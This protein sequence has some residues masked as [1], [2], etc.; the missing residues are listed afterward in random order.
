MQPLRPDPSN[1]YHSQRAPVSS[2]ADNRTSE[3]VQNTLAASSSSE[4]RAPMKGKQNYQ[5]LQPSTGSHPIPPIPSSFAEPRA[6]MRGKQATQQ[7]LQPPEN[8]I[9]VFHPA[10]QRT[11]YFTEPS[12]LLEPRAPMRGQQALQQPLQP[13]SNAVPGVHYSIPAIPGNLAGSSVP[14]ESR[15]PMRGQ[16]APQ[17]PLQPSSGAAAVV[18]SQTMAPLGQMPSDAHAPMK[19]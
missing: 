6:P 13:S 2:S 19:R 18:Y 10:P 14:S 5:P 17:Q 16:Q 1:P 9:P 8:T 12:V 4:P 15:A 11:N 7:P 3:V